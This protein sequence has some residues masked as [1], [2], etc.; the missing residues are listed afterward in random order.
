MYFIILCNAPSFIRQESICSVNYMSMIEN[1]SGIFF[2]ETYQDIIYLCSREQQYLGILL[3]TW[4]QYGQ[5]L[6]RT[7]VRC[8]VQT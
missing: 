1:G 3:K 6:V 5:S 7:L 4:L 2:L 8:T